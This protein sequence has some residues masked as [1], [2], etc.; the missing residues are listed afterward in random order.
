MPMLNMRLIYFGTS[1][2]AVPVL[3]I[4]KEQ[5]DWNVMLVVTE[6]AKPAGRKQEITQS[7]VS[8]YARRAGL[9]IV[10]P[11]SLKNTE[12]IDQIRSAQADVMIVAAHGKIISPGIFNLPPLG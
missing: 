5:T 6:P 7:P 8:V 2:F 1:E 9:K 3:Q 12:V 4:I 10:A 11:P